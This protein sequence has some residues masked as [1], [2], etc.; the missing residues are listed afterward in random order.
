MISP[1]DIVATITFLVPGFVALKWF[2]WFGLKTKR[3]DLEWTLWS[4]VAAALIGVVADQFWPLPADATTV[5][6][7]RLIGSLIL[8]VGL[9]VL[10]TVGWDILRAL[11]PNIELDAGLQA[12]GVLQKA[13]W[14]QLRL[15]SG[16]TIMGHPHVLSN[17]A[18]TDKQDIYLTNLKWVDHTGTYVPI[19]GAV[20]ILV[21]QESIDYALVIDTR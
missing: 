11:L 20:G 10:L 4:L 21:R 13:N 19:E 15:T 7:D 16:P 2:Y 1:D 12:W 9:G 5:T 3:S 6:P 18:Q 14:V 17:P 8:G